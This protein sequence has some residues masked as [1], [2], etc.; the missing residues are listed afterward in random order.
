M[1]RIRGLPSHRRQH[2]GQAMR[3]HLVIRRPEYVAGTSRRP[4]VGVFTQT[5]VGRKPV[6]W[7]RIAS[8]E[9][10]WMKWSAGPVVARAVVSDFR[11]LGECSPDQLRTAVAG[12]ALHDLTAYWESLGPRFSAVVV[13]L[14]DEN[15]LDEPHVIDARSHGSSWFVF[16]N[17]AARE[18]WMTAPIAPKAGP[19]DPRDSRTAPP[20]IRFEVFRRDSY[21]CQYCGRR[22]P[23]FPL[24]VDH[25]I[26]WSR[27]GATAVGNLRTTCSECNLGKS[28]RHA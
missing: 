16:E 22:A 8:G 13:Y 21:T 20:A 17:S 26:P 27:G 6:P 24:H 12:H 10:V 9:S 28:N 19:S 11:L 4:G 25:V 5:S 15:W 2:R 1:P 3:E 14:T 23:E 18:K 7:G